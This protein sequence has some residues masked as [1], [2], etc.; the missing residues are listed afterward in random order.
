MLPL[1]YD[2]RD[3]KLMVNEREAATL[4]RICQRY[5]ALGPVL[6][7]KDELDRDGIV[8]KVRV[9]RHG[10]RAGGRPLARGALYLM[11]RGH[12]SFADLSVL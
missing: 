11:Q 5:A 6:V 4:R 1:G 3:R 12:R 10:H 8:S 2:V 7:L 9:D